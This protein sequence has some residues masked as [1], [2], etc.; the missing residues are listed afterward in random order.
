MAKAVC[1]LHNMYYTNLGRAPNG[2]ANLFRGGVPV[3]AVWVG[4]AEAL[5]TGT[6]AGQRRWD[7]SGV[8]RGLG[9]RACGDFGVPEQEDWALGVVLGDECEEAVVELAGAGAVALVGA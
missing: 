3:E 6:G 1:N 8:G 2:A 9:V 7:G 5:G 4:R